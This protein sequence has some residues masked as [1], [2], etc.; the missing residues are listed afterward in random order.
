MAGI[1]EAASTAAVKH[2]AATREFRFLLA[3]LDPS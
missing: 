1:G 3:K 2:I